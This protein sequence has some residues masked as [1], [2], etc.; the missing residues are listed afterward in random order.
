VH[1]VLA[2]EAEIQLL[3][4]GGAGLAHGGSGPTTTGAYS[5]VPTVSL[6]RGRSLVD[7]IAN[8]AGYSFR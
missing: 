6:P 3:A 2:S 7:F 1:A 5:F 8:I 4:K